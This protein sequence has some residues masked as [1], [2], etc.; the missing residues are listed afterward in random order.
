MD[1]NGIDIEQSRDYIQIYWHKYIDIVMISHCC[2]EEKSKVSDKPPFPLP[3]GPL[4]Q[5][6]SNSG[7]KIRHQVT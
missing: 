6:F 1:F 4:K 3:P 2:N 7:P 5:L